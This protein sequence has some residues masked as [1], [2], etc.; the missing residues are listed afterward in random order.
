[1]TSISRMGKKT[2]SGC[3]AV[4]TLFNKRGTPL[5]LKKESKTPGNHS[6]NETS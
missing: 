1:M 2:A 6:D 5:K 4:P 3:T